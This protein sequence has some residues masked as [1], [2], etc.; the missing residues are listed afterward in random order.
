MVPLTVAMVCPPRLAVNTVPPGTGLCRSR[1]EAQRSQARLCS[2]A[3]KER[4]VA[5]RWP[6]GTSTS[7]HHAECPRARGGASSSLSVVLFAALPQS[8]NVPVAL[9]PRERPVV[10]RLAVARELTAVGWQTRFAQFIAV[11]S[12][13]ILADTL[14]MSSPELHQSLENQGA[15][16]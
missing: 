8:D 16:S 6:Q 15:S 7:F 13:S 5:G 3:P 10:G 9:E 12:A 1:G 2:L 4:M 14:R 11:C